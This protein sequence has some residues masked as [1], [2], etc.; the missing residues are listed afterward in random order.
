MAHTHLAAQVVLKKNEDRRIVR[1]HPWVFS[2]EIRE[3]RG[4]P[5]IGDV[6]EVLTA[7][8]LTIGSGFFNPHSLIAVR[9]LSPVVEEIDA[10][11]FRGRLRQALELR[12][13]LYPDAETYRLVNGEADFLPG[14]VIDK[15][16]DQVVVQTLS[17][18]MDVRLPVICDLLEE[19][20]HPGAIVERNEA[21]F[22]AMELLPQKKGVLR[23][24]AAPT[25]ITENGVLYTV[26][27]LGGQKTG[28]FLDQRE[29]RALVGRWSRGMNVLDCFSNEGGF[30]LNAAR[31]GA[32][33]V[34]GV[35]S[36][37]E[38][39]AAAGGNAAR[40]KIETVRFERGDV[41]EV[42]VKLR[43]EGKLFDFIVLD[44]PSFA[45]N[46]KTVPAARKGYRDLHARAFR[47]LAS[48]GLLATASCSHHIEPEAFLEDIE[49][50][51]RRQ[52]RRLQLLEWRGAAPDHPTLPSVPETA[53]LKFGLFRVLAGGGNGEQTEGEKRLS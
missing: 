28:F 52:G 16:N 48:G 7:G 40:N 45:R 39:V 17:Y 36:S 46:R 11:F 19:L 27:V 24:S 2:N 13:R 5:A 32:A 22:R 50:A 38:A 31:G 51:A 4:S 21:S 23:G 30:A 9:V 12:R 14:L 20:L 44:P 3:M 1:G 8:G 6:V 37:E 53:Y 35:D 25:E 10:D 47:V 34:L 29:N 43:E 41:F 18:G 33:S 42:L 26:D 49:T 15:F